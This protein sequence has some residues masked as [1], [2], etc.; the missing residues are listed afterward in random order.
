MHVKVQTITT[1][2]FTWTLTLPVEGSALAP[3]GC[4]QGQ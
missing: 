3:L 4:S 1:G 2:E